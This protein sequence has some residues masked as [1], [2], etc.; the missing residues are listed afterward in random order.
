MKLLLYLMNIF[1]GLTSRTNLIISKFNLDRTFKY[2]W[3]MKPSGLYLRKKKGES[4]PI[5]LEDG[6]IHSFGYVKSKIPFSICHD[7]NGIYYS[8]RSKS[9]LFRYF[10]DQL[11]IENVIRSRKIIKLWKECSIS[12]Y[13]FPDFIVPPSF[14]YVLLI[15]QVFG[16]LSIYYG[17]ATRDSF[18][19]MFDFASKNFSNSFFKLK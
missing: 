12:K 6:F 10:N 2:V 4:S 5:Y 14:K 19:Q 1:F 16:D 13:N 8:Y 18:N 17:G 11:S 3:G 15:D 7:K 9:D